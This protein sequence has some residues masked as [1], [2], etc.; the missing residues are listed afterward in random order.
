MIAHPRIALVAARA[1]NGVIGRDGGMP[2]RMSSDLK[3]F[4]AITLGKPIVMG[5]LTWD[6]IGAKPL[7]GRPNL[8]VSRDQSLQVPGAWAFSDLNLALAAGRSLAAAS[9]V[10][11][12]CVIGGGVIYAQTM[13]RADRLYLTEVAVSLPG[14]AF[15]PQFDE[16]L[17]KL[18]E[19]KEFPCGDGDQFACV[20]RVL[21]R[22]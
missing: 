4:K 18:T 20:V 10:D 8:V 19:R 7:P 11:E 1:A 14:D 3:N 5:R 2:W 21:D 9:G 15:F 12:V 6:S 16:T 22:I 17:F 13:A